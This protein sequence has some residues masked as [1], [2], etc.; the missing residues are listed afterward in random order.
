MPQH[1]SSLLLLLSCRY[2]QLIKQAANTPASSS[3]LSA[4]QLL[5][6]QPPSAARPKTHSS[7]GFSPAAAKKHGA[8]V[9]GSSRPATASPVSNGNNSSSASNANWQYSST[10][11]AA[12]AGKGM[13]SQGSALLGQGLRPFSAAPAVPAVSATAPTAASQKPSLLGA[14][15]A[16]PP[17]ASKAS[18]CSSPASASAG[19]ASSSE[20]KCLNVTTAQAFHGLK[21]LYPDLWAATA[22]I[23]RPQAAPNKNFVSEVRLLQHDAVQCSSSCWH[24]DV[25]GVCTSVAAF[26]AVLRQL[27]VTLLQRLSPSG[28]AGNNIPTAAAVMV[29]ALPSCSEACRGT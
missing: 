19:G 18:S 3:S 10:M 29:A 11:R 20:P 28:R 15:T 1:S 21:E 25:L 27:C 16:A 9:A 8:A 2:M 5:Q 4:S 24:K 14:A 26:Y 17:G 6:H 7:L 12:A 13:S 23:C 22:P